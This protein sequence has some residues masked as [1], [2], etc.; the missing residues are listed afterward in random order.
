MKIFLLFAFLILLALMG[1]GCIMNN[2]F[3][4]IEIDK[5][6]DLTKSEDHKKLLMDFKSQ[7]TGAESILVTSHSSNFEIIVTDKSSEDY[8]GGA[9]Q[10][11]LDKKTGDIKTGWHEAPMKIEKDQ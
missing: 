10:Y 2:K 8:T 3:E 11:F 7:H 6:I 4:L 1:F 5:A 9:A